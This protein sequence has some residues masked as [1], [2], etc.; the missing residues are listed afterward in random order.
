ML[1][2]QKKKKK[3]LNNYLRLSSLFFQ[4]AAIIFLGAYLGNY[5]DQNQNNET[6][7]L[8]IIFS[9]FSIALSIYYVFKEVKSNDKK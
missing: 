1:K 6:P 3:Q 8:T 5:L 7:I 2:K 9:L 4:M